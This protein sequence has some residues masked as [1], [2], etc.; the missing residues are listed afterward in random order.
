MQYCEDEFNLDVE[1]IFDL[2]L[3]DPKFKGLMKDLTHHEAALAVQAAIGVLHSNVV[4]DRGGH[5]D[6]SPECYLMIALL[7]QWLVRHLCKLLMQLMTSEALVLHRNT[8]PSSYL[9]NYINFHTHFSIQN[10][11]FKYRNALESTAE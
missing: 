10:L 3:H 1:S 9:E 11:I 6:V 5:L 2:V 8:M 4:P 7:Q